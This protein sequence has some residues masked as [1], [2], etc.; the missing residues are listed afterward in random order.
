[1]VAAATANNCVVNMGTLRR[2]EEGYDAAT[3][4]IHSGKLNTLTSYM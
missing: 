3:E 2:Y 1:V 4:L